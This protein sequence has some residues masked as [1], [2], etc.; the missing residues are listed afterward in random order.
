[1]Y[2]LFAGVIMTLIAYWYAPDACAKDRVKV[3]LVDSGEDI[4]TDLINEIREKAKTHNIDNLEIKSLT[5]LVKLYKERQAGE[6][7]LLAP[8]GTKSTK[9]VVETINDLPI[10]SVALPR[11]NY[12]TLLKMDRAERSKKAF[13]QFSAIYLDQPVARRISLIKQILPRANR[14][15]VLLGPATYNMKDELIQGFQTYDYTVNV[16]YYEEKQNLVK[17]LD[18]LL[19]NSDALMGIADPAVFNEQNARNLLLT[20]YRWKVPMIGISPAYVRA[21]AMAA[22]YTSPA[23]FAS[24]F[25]E[26]IDKLQTCDD[27][28]VKKSGY[29]KY[30]DV[31]VNYRVAEALGIVVENEDLLRKKISRSGT[32]S[33]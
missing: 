26:I 6:C 24:Q 22:V 7:L 25:V 33:E 17:V 2:R 15:S 14:I 29:P 16:G 4:Y 27:E 20:A 1:M 19:E 18:V 8:V 10:L 30:F 5:E 31:K 9:S 13:R 23:Q 28:I 3:V 32:A 12:Q 11:V 21:G